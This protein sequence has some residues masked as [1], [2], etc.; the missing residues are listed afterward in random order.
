MWFFAIFVLGA[1]V[2][3]QARLWALVRI[4][5]DPN[6]LSTYEEPVF[7]II[8]VLV[9]LVSVLNDRLFDTTALRTLEDIKTVSATSGSQI[10]AIISDQLSP[11]ILELEKT[12]DV[13][14]HAA[15]LIN[16]AFKETTQSAKFLIYIGS[17]DLQKDPPEARDLEEDSPA[18]EYQSAVSQARNGHLNIER[19]ISL[20]EPADFQHRQPPTKEAYC[21]WIQKQI[22]NLERNPNYTFWHTTR[23]PQW[24]SSR[25]SIFSAKALIDVVGNGNSGVLIRGE[26]ISRAL[27]DGSRRLFDST[28]VRPKEFKSGQL[29]S[30]LDLLTAGQ[31]SHEGKS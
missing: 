23:A 17:G 9:L 11:S 1:A 29:K 26:K 19:F 24:G 13:L 27:L 7:L 16:N 31:Q 12:D 30:Y 28:H 10:R 14:H 5:A 4:G 22:D 3:W 18:M 25:S 20:M 2:G 15:D 21:A 6:H 8:A